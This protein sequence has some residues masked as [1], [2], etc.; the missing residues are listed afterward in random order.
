MNQRIKFEEAIEKFLDL[1]KRD[2]EIIGIL[3][4]GS[5]VK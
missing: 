2:E 5:F 3:V 1:I 4:T